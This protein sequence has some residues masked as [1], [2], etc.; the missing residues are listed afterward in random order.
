MAQE[1]LVERALESDDD[2]TRNTALVAPAADAAAA[3]NNN[4][5]T[6]LSGPLFPYGP[7]TVTKDGNPAATALF[8]RHYSAKAGRTSRRIVGPGHRIVLLTPEQD[9]LFIWRI[10]RHRADQQWG[11]ECT[12][13][14]N[15]SRHLSSD[16][17]LWAETIACLHWPPLVRFFTYVN[18]TKIKSTN[19]GYAF[20][21][22]GWR[23]T[24]HISQKQRLLLLEKIIKASDEIPLPYEV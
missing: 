16:L 2:T 4:V 19:P 24:D 14:R 10:S 12:V 3:T 7:W 11:A 8:N 18:P 13:F 1:Y 23:R 9:A 15:E 6:L 20:Q 22:A 17:I 5:R 21:C